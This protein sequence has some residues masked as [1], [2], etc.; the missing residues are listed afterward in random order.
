MLDLT[1]NGIRHT[2][3]SPDTAQS[4]VRAKIFW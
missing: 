1:L 4:G 2:V 3:L